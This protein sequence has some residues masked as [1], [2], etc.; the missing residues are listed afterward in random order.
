MKQE[1]EEVNKWSLITGENDSDSDDNNPAH[2]Q[3]YSDP[4]NVT[5]SVA[6]VLITHNDSA[7]EK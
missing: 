1:L 5:R 3:V 4:Y 7:P 6:F 2:C